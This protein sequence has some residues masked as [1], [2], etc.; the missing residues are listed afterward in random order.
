MRDNSHIDFIERWAFFVRNNPDK[1][2]AIQTEFINSQFIKTYAF[3]DR[4]AKQPG[5]RQKIIEL[6]GIKNPKALK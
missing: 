6:Y 1:W 3:L 2:K 5:G 4:L